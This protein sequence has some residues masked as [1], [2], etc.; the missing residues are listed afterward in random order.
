[1]SVYEKIE[2]RMQNAF[3]E[4]LAKEI[5]EKANEVIYDTNFQDAIYH[6]DPSASG[7]VK[8][9]IRAAEIVRSKLSTNIN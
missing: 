9:L 1:M 6:R 7:E 5:E 4:S 3:L 8:G 2:N